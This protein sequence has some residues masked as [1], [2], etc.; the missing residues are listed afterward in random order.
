M[1]FSY[2]LEQHASYG[3]IFV[4]AVEIQYLRNF[5]NQ[6]AAKALS[7]LIVSLRLLYSAQQKNPTEKRDA[8]VATQRFFPSRPSADNCGVQR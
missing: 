1:Y 2:C 7:L 6:N 5:C 8:R 3:R 4:P